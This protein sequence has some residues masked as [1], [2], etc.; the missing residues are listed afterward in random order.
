[1]AKAAGHAGTQSPATTEDTTRVKGGAVEPKGGVNAGCR[2]GYGRVSLKRCGCRGRH[3]TELQRGCLMLEAGPGRTGSPEFQGGHWKRGRRRAPVSCP[4]GRGP[5]TAENH[6]EPGPIIKR[7]RNAK[8]EPLARLGCP[9]EPVAV[10]R[11]VVDESSPKENGITWL[12]SRDRTPPHA[13][14]V[15]P[16]R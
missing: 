1:M 14:P 10:P 8:R 16:S 12:I 5:A 13:R 11:V 6:D 2:D 3:R 15:S 7:C 9:P 4:T